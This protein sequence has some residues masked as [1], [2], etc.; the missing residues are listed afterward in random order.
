MKEEIT[1]E[2]AKQLMEI[3]GESRGVHFINDSQ[4]V[5]SKKG[6]KGL[7]KV[8]KELKELGFPINYRKIKNTDFFP[9]GLRII[10]LLA[11]KKTL[12]WD[13]EEIKNLCGFSAGM[14]FI[15][16]LYMKYFYSIPQMVKMS[17]R[18]W[19]EYWTKGSFKVPDYNEEEKW[20]IVR[21]ED[22]DL[23]PIYCCCLEGYLKSI[24]KMIVGAEKVI[25]KETKCSFKE[26]KVH[27]FLIKW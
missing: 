2:I 7:D 10:S 22:Q 16:R 11:I 12:G 20:A 19:R 6:E 23:H 15:I 17:P 8:E 13:N 5:L 25:C 4:Y 24:I 21:I 14:S 9:A 26:G 1:K 27:E 3:E 18:I